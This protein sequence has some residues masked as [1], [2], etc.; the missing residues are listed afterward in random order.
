[1]SNVDLLKEVDI[2]EGLNEEQYQRVAEICRE[3]HYNNGDVVFEENSKG[4]ELFIINN[5]RV[6]I[7][8]SAIPEKAKDGE[9]AIATIVTLGRGQVFG[10]V[11][12]VDEGLRS[13]T[14]R[15]VA[16]NSRL[17]SLKRADFM[18]M[19][20]DAPTIGFVVMRNIAADIA[21][22]IRYTDLMLKGQLVWRPDE[23]K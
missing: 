5:G 9:G 12:L 18:Q 4:D 7:K 16:D 14:A 11:A 6:E 8:V 1:M 13:A 17:Y 19:C 2:F 20:K 21:F 23:E 3:L 22:K 15:C 10:E